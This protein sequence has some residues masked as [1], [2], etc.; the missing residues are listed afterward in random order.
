[1][2]FISDLGTDDWFRDKFDDLIFGD[3]DDLTRNDD[4]VNQHHDVDDFDPTQLHNEVNVFNPFGS[5][6][7][8]ENGFNIHYNPNQF[9]VV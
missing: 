4:L 6:D 7:A 8:E 5:W 3:I 2:N 1:M 9:D